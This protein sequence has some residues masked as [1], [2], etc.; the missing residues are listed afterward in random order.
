MDSGLDK[1]G[2]VAHRQVLGLPTL[3]GG[4]RI[5]AVP[6]I[7]GLA[8]VALLAVAVFFVLDGGGGEKDG[9]GVPTALSAASP[10]VP[11]TAQTAPSTAAAIAPVGVAVAQA[12]AEG[13]GTAVIWD[14]QAQSDAITYS[15][16]GVAPLAE[17]KAYVGWLASDDGL[18]KLST[19]P[20]TVQS[21]GSI[22]HTVDQNSRG[23]TG[24]NLMHTFNKVIITV[25]DRDSTFAYSLG[26]PVFIHE[27]PLEA[28]EHIRHLLT[29][30]PP[31]SDKGI[32]T[33]LKDQLGVAIFH[34]S[35]A[36]QSNT[37]EDLRQHTE[38]V[39]NI[40]EGLDGQNYGDL[41][42]NGVIENP[43]DDIGVLAYA[44]DRKHA[45]FAASEAREDATIAAHA[46]LVDSHGKN[47]EE[48]AIQA[49]DLSLQILGAK[50]LASAQAFMNPGTDTVKSLL[51]AA[52]NGQE[53]SGQGGA[54]Q[55]YVEAQ[56]MATYT[57]KPLGLAPQSGP[58]LSSPG[59]IVYGLPDN[60]VYRVEA[61]EGAT[62]EDISAGLDALSPGP[63][64][65]LIN[66]SPNGNWLVLES[67]R[68]DKDCE[69]WACLAIV[70][71]DLSS[72]EAVRAV[73][74]EGAVVHPSQG[75]VAVASSG[76][77]TI[78]Q[79]EGVG[80][81]V[82]DLFAITRTNGAWGAPLALTGG[83]PYLWHLNP[84]IS[85][86]GSTVLFQCGDDSWNGHSI[87]EVST[88][89]SRVPGSGVRG[90]GSGERET[91]AS[92]LAG[93]EESSRKEDNSGQGKDGP[94]GAIAQGGN[95]R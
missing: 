92:S 45:K 79:Q 18:L 73:L 51:E 49:R 12:A 28:M 19:G 22:S 85:E 5:P 26:P 70:A 41:D 17:D 32:L 72:G 58:V 14:D 78:Y 30:W 71:G 57:L 60:R 21:D 53:S 39:I 74:A 91:T 25:E 94:A 69:N 24:V 47:S 35:L 90:R 38:H 36:Q 23:Y 3:E 54:V 33:N 61:Q 95:G 10:S 84:S 55:A 13:V 31:G 56:L 64:D 66:T 77:V 9:G 48:L 29:N 62:P 82:S 89:G 1:Q 80:T 52:L 27:V 4:R 11:D 65:L 16:T 63:N 68:F 43:G 67:E 81:H 88:D 46:S 34:A 87:C 42:G 15:M 44:I 37:L 6:L 93:K 40:I 7:A 8:A 20:M 50:D 59:Y 83:S 76:D 2:S 75:V 86:D